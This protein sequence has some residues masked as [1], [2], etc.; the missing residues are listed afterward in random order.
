MPDREFTSAMDRMDQA[1]DEMA[2]VLEE[3]RGITVDLK[4]SETDESGDTPL[5]K[6]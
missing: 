4:E 5:E 1:I 3:L 6:R 2:R